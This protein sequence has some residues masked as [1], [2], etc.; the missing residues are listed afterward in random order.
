MTDLIIE[1]ESYVTI[2]YSRPLANNI[3][4]LYYICHNS[5]IRLASNFLP[6]KLQC[7]IADL[8]QIS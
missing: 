5:I 6:Q 4:K 3:Y 2:G 8:L 1:H 7:A